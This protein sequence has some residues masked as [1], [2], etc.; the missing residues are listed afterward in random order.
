MA[1]KQAYKTKIDIAFSGSTY[2]QM[3]ADKLK[4]IVIEHMY[5]DRVM[6]VI[7]MSISV[8]SDLYDKIYQ[9]KNSAKIYLRVQRVDAYSNTSLYKD[10]IND[11]FTYILPSSSA[12][13]SKRLNEANQNVDSSF[14]TL[15]IGLMS[16]EI[17]NAL[18]KTFGGFLKNIDQ[19]SL[20][21]KAIED[22]KIVLKT[23][24]YNI[25]YNNIYV[26][27]MS[28]RNEMLKFIFSIDPFYD[29]EF[30]YFIDFNTSY[31]LDMTGEAVDAND[32]QYTD[33]IID[34]RSFTDSNAYN[35][36]M[37]VRN[38]SYYFYINPASSK[39][40]YD[41]GTENIANQ[42][43]AGDFDDGTTVVDLNIN[44]NSQ[45]TTKQIFE[46]LEQS[47]SI[48]YKNAIESSQ[49]CFEMYKENIDSRYITPNKTYN[50]TNYE[51]YDEYSGRYVL[52]YK[53]EIIHGASS[54]FTSV[55]TFGLKRVG[56]IQT[57]GYET[58][59]NSQNKL[60]NSKTTAKTSS[61]ST[62][63]TRTSATRKSSTTSSK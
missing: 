30:M 3:N 33:I 53:K 26:P 9:E 20:V 34:V 59:S 15:T 44:K 2:I 28:S 46:R 57:I 56:N 7:Y 40:Y 25:K 61:Y 35:E 1:S 22:T 48:V 54:D 55:T 39:P 47:Q 58:I 14:R 31:L 36:G 6:P 16:M 43:V 5:V 50:I 21:Y 12:E 60:A 52:L 29:T 13:Y 19:Y 38:G 8:E 17:M 10:Y 32:G 62:K 4:Y 49:L 37:E 45:V 27:P 24:S 51:G 41:S 23:P 18:R 63:K 11:Q 42:I